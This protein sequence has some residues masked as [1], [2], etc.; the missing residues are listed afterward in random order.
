[1]RQHRTGPSL[2]A[3]SSTQ[4]IPYSTEQKKFTITYMVRGLASRIYKELRLSS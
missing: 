3:A 1:M 4:H 2:E